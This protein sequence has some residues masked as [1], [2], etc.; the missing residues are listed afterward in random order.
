[1]DPMRVSASITLATIDQGER[2]P[3]MFLEGVNERIAEESCGSPKPALSIV[4]AA[5]RQ[6]RR[7]LSQHLGGGTVA[8]IRIPGDFGANRALIVEAANKAQIVETLRL[9][10]GGR[11]VTGSRQ[12]KALQQPSARCHRGHCNET[13]QPASNGI[14][15]HTSTKTDTC[16][17]GLVISKI[18]AIGIVHERVGTMHN[19]SVY[20]GHN[21]G[22]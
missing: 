5:T 10:S 15:G 9:G 8:G 7:H 11:P 16:E 2:E 4:L 12:D 13:A 22:S 6:T 14:G 20:A 3:G 17:H 19:P 21:E 1:M 18:F